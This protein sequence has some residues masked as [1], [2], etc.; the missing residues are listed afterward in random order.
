MPSLTDIVDQLEAHRTE[1]QSELG[2]LDA[3]IKALRGSSTSNESG[4][5]RVSSPATRRQLSAAGRKAISLAQKARWAK[6]S[7]S[8]QDKRD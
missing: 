1:V 2:R 4:T 3:A 7:A 6:R 8:G 5:V